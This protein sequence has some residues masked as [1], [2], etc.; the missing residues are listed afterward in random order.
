VP[1]YFDKVLIDKHPGMNMAYWNLQ[2]RKIIGEKGK[3]KVN[4]N[5]DLLF[6]HFS[7]YNPFIEDNIADKQNRYKLSE[8]PDL[9]MLYA[10]Y[11]EMVNANYFKELKQIPCAYGRKPKPLK[12]FKRVRAAIT[13]PLRKVIHFIEE[14]I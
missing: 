3:Y 13:N 7:T 8:R 6:F 12:R 9:Q 11:E 1:C 14:T 4:D 10:E 5:F 2:E